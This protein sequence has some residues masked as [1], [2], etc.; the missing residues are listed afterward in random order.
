MIKQYNAADN[1]L[2]SIIVTTYNSADYIS[3][4]IESILIQSYRNFEIVVVDDG[5][6]D[7]TAA[8]VRG[9]KNEPIKYF[10]KE[11]GGV[12]SAAFRSTKIQWGIH[13]PA[14]QRR[15]DDARL[16]R[17]SPAGI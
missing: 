9:F 17:Q 4:A 12:A 6:T 3:R 15:Y 1:P 7:N 13:N 5:S 10:F 8:I 2:V 14:R 11:N 16:H